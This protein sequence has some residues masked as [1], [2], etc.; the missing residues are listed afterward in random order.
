[1]A[2]IAIIG[3]GS[4]VF[5]RTFLNDLFSTEALKGSDYILMGPTM[6]KLKK[7]EEYA[8]RVIE[9]NE[10]S[11]QVYT[12]TDR[13][14]ALAGADYVIAT[15]QIGGGDIIA[16]DRD[17]PARYGI[18]QIIGD[19]LGPGGVFRAMRTIPVMLDLA[20]DMEELCPDALLL[21]YVN[22]MAMVC[23]ALGRGGNVKFVGLC[24]GVQTTLDLIARYTGVKKEEID[25]ISAGINHMAWFLNISHNGKDLYPILRQNIEKPEYY[26]SEK[27]RCEVMRHFGYF[28]T[29]S[30]DHLS[31][32]LPWFRKDNRMLDLYC[33]N[34]VF[35][36][37]EKSDLNESDNAGKGNIDY[38]SIEKDVLEP[39]SVEYCSHIIE[40]METDR[41]FKFNGNVMN[42][43]FI[44]NLPF[45]SCVEVPIFA[46]KSGLHP[47]A[48]GKLPPQLAALNQ[49]NISVQSLAVEAAL[50]G[51]PELLFSA[52]A[53]DPLT[54]SVLTPSE[55][56]DMIIDMMEINKNFLPQFKGKSLRK[57]TTVFIP[58]GTVGVEI[59]LD[60][61]LAVAHR[62]EQLIKGG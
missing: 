27:V 58:E 53:M 36:S 50:T 22:P 62:I 30:T 17:I 47:T 10:L 41:V 37:K 46:D 60:P 42:N 8:L 45:D 57:V 55:A 54:S 4:V 35:V 9:R 32:Y 15:F 31:E 24:H 16:Y 21:N 13:R 51:D 49:S 56:R 5:T 19:T 40:A 61:A 59:P 7:V 26:L 3:A 20:R 14:E 52:I 43:G 28:M 2:R 48:V 23:L 12:T 38:F 29:E 11:A 1:M 18:N 39:R 33:D 34:P 25:F 6:S 44:S